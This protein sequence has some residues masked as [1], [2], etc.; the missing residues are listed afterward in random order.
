VVITAFHQL[1]RREVKWP[2]LVRDNA[3]KMNLRPGAKDG[4]PGVRSWIYMCERGVADKSGE[5]RRF[6]RDLLIRTHPARPS[7]FVV[8]FPLYVRYAVPQS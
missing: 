3:E 4:E 8:P 2:Y 1:H 5:V 7:S 6:G